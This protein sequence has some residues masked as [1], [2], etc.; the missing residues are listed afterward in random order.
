M[1]DDVSMNESSKFSGSDNYVE[2]PIELQGVAAEEM[3]EL[4][5]YFVG[6]PDYI[7]EFKLE[8]GSGYINAPLQELA[9]PV[10]N[11]IFS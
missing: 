3:T 11:V 8:G 4:S 9:A 10:I 6:V 1:V 5:L 7:T 2:L